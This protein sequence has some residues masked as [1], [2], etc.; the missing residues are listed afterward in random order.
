MLA[1][2]WSYF[3]TLS[4]LI[5]NPTRAFYFKY[6]APYLPIGAENRETCCADGRL[7]MELTDLAA[8][9]ARHFEVSTAKG[10]EWLVDKIRL[11][12]ANQIQTPNLK[13]LRL[14]KPLAPMPMRSRVLHAVDEC[15]GLVETLKDIPGQLLGAM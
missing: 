8:D 9:V 15:I 4:F 5:R 1:A 12:S 11:P 3:T 7:E 14:R 6:S 10:V 13:T 2:L